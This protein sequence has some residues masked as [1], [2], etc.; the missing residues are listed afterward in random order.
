M[1]VYTVHC[2][3]GTL[4]MNELICF[5]IIFVARHWDKITRCS[6]ISHLN[7]IYFCVIIRWQRSLC[8]YGRITGRQRP[9]RIHLSDRKTYIHVTTYSNGKLRYISTL[10]IDID[11]IDAICTQKRNFLYFALRLTQNVELVLFTV[12]V[13]TNDIHFFIWFTENDH[14]Y[15]KLYHWSKVSVKSSKIDS[16]T[17]PACFCSW[18][19]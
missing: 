1:R 5:V 6:D 9:E 10:C 8:L 7:N 19:Y 3:Y 11:H 14:S 15:C 4:G 16:T 12:C 13:V 2:P 18:S 17:P